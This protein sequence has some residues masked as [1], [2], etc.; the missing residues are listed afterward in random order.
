MA[1]QIQIHKALAEVLGIKPDKDG[2][3]FCS[4]KLLI[5]VTKVEAAMQLNDINLKIKLETNG[6]TR[7]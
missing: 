2:F 6:K 1:K 4:D 3:Y 7:I 5:P